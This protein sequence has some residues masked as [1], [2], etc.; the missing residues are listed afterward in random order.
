LTYGNGTSAYNT[1]A[2]GTSGQI[3][4]SSGSAPQ[5][6]TLSGV[7]VTTFSGGTTGLTPS[8]ATSGAITLGGTLNVANGGT[9]LNSL[10][11]TYIPYGN[12]TGALSS[13]SSLTYNSGVLSA[14]S[15]I[16]TET[17]SGSLSAGA[18][19]YGTLG[20]SDYNIFGSFSTSA[21][22]Y[23]QAILQNTYTGTGASVDFIV[24]NDQGRASS[25]YGDFGI[26][27]SAFTAFTG[28]GSISSTTLTITAVSTGALQVGSVISGTG[29]TS[30][31]TIT[32][33]LT[34]TGGTGTYTVSVSQ[35]AASTT[36]TSTTGSLSLAN[37]TYMYASNG[38]LVIGTAT[39]NGVHIVVNNGV[40]DAMFIPAS[41]PILAPVGIAGGAF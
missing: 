28:T 26:N 9:G 10:T 6:S 31:T 8:T 12:G 27:S 38:D 35:T 25:Y 7:A 5:W 40:S 18:F 34:G 20:Y 2:I 11:S 13:S 24:S 17:I 30:G 4:T 15:H 29:V 3:L 23:A 16:A 21:N 19:S 32:A 36:I 39:S 41:G 37:A 14:P 1:L 33:F 22:T